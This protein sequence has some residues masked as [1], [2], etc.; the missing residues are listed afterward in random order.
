MDFAISAS[1]LSPFSSN[2]SL[3]Y[4]NSSLDSVENSAFGASASVDNG[5]L[6][7][8]VTWK[9]TLNNRINRTTLL[10]QSTVNTLGHINIISRRP[11]TP[12]LSLLRLNRNRQR[13]TNGLT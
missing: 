1:H 13:R 9:H 10:T 2:F 11:P 5:D 12:I 7:L 4:N 6:G 3:L 8:R